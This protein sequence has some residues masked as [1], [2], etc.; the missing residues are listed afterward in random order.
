MSLYGV[1]CLKNG[2]A[3]YRD[4][5]MAMN[6]D[7]YEDIDLGNGRAERRF[8]NKD[9]ELVGIEH[10]YTSFSPPIRSDDF[11]SYSSAERHKEE[12]PDEI[13]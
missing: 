2:L 12:W 7:R 5:I 6:Y 11:V 3:L 1:A 9:G 4:T 8:Y 10:T 13:E